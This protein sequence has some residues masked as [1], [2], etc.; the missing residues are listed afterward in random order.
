MFQTFHCRGKIGESTWY[1][2]MFDH[3][4]AIVKVAWHCLPDDNDVYKIVERLWK[5]QCGYFHFIA[6]G[7]PPTDNLCEQSIRHVVIDR[8]ITQGTRS[9]W[10]DRWQ[11]RM[12]SVLSTCAQTGRDVLLFLRESV[13]SLF[14]KRKT[15]SLLTK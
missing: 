3:R 12:W 4:D 8:K 14:D 9:D 15:L 7:V 11:E 2:R 10:G 1:R 13:S 6:L 5:E